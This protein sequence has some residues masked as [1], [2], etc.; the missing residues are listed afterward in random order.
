M[1]AVILQGHNLSVRFGRTR[2]LNGLSISV[3][4]GQLVGLIGPNGAGKTTLL[5]TLCGLQRPHTGDVLIHDQPL[6]SDREILRQIGFTPD[7]PPVYEQLTLRDYLRFIGKG[8]DLSR[9][10]TEERIDFW[11]EQLWLT[12]KANEKIKALS[13]GMRQRIGIART[14]MPNPSVVL[15]DEPSSGLDPAGRAQFRQFLITLREQGKAIIVS[16]HILAD[17][18]QYCSHIAIMSAGALVRTDTVAAFANGHAEHLRRYTIT[19]SRSIG[20]LRRRLEEVHGLEIVTVDGDRA[21]FAFSGQRDHAAELLAVMIRQGM[22]VASF[23]PAELDLEQA[24]LQT[25]IRQVD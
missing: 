10:Q 23:A 12:E 6:G 18:D 19:L 24:Y 3:E 2:A 7:T 8:Y 1:G 17:M 16:S 9:S 4:S 22:P 21:E 14:M 20:D 25:G 13:R 15:L 5:R 11:L